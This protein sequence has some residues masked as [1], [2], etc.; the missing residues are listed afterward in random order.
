MKYIIHL[1]LKNM[2]IEESIRKIGEIVSLESI[3]SKIEVLSEK[4]DLFPF[5]SKRFTDTQDCKSIPLLWS[6]KMIAVQKWPIFDL[7]ESEI[8][9][10]NALLKS[11]ID[12]SGE[13]INAVLTLLPPGKEMRRF[14]DP[15]LRQEKYGAC[16]R[17]QI[18]IVLNPDCSINTAYGSTVEI[19]EGSVYE[20]NHL[21]NPVGFKNL[22]ETPR[23]HLT[24]DFMPGDIISKYQI[25][26]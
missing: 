1:K 6:E 13:T 9:E 22:G 26:I 19:E 2:H 15:I 14:K 5:L 16:H 10:I 17:I 12:E 3:A 8:N 18:P 23:I 20:I 25:S 4:W 7:F 24:I 11:S 21:L